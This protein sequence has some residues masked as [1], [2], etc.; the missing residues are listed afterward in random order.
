MNLSHIP[1]KAA[2]RESPIY[3]RGRIVFLARL[4]V[5]QGEELTHDRATTDD[6]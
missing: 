3:G 2:V 1:P 4:G 5:A 6:D